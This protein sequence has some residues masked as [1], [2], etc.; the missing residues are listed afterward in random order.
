MSDLSISQG[1]NGDYQRDNV[2]DEPALIQRLYASLTDKEGF[3]PFLADLVQAINACSGILVNLRREPMAIEYIWHTGFPEGFMEWYGN[4]NMLEHDAVLN[5]AVSQ[6]PGVFHSTLPI[7]EQSPPKDDYQRW[8]SDQNMLDSAWLVAHAEDSSSLIL[9]LQRT[10]QQGPYTEPELER[11]NR[12]VPYIRQAVQLYQQTN[13][14]MEQ[15]A[16]FAAVINAL[17]IATLILN[18]QLNVVHVNKAAQGILETEKTITLVDDRLSFQNKETQWHYMQYATESIRASMGLQLFSSDSLFVERADRSSLVLCVNPIEGL[19]EHRG[20]AMV[21]LYDPQVRSLPGARLIA[22]YFSLTQAEALLCEDLCV[23][24]SLKEIS[25]IRHKSEATLRSYLKQ[26][27]QKT[28]LN[29]QGQLVS[30]I[31][32]ALMH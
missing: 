12:L 1:E 10:Y 14:Q 23:G 32:S 16:S 28:G 9:A 24:L 2:F 18:D 13:K 31:L 11:L 27:F 20:G 26:V 29:R 21:T 3:H 8:E 5:H 19:S 25:E 15:A 4:N 30:Q 22:E 7:L 6:S 17:P